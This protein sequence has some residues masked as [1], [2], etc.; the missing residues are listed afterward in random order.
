MINWVLF[1]SQIQTLLL[2]I[3][4]FFEDYDDEVKA[5]YTKDA[6]AEIAA[7]ITNPHFLP[8]ECQRYENLVKQVEM[9]RRDT[10]DGSSI[11]S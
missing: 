7:R 8:R 10:T 11:L 5:V 9:R 4:L 3:F 6:C 1:H 2:M